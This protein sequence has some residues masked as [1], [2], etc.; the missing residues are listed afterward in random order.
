MAEPAQVEIRR[1]LA[2]LAEQR[3][4]LIERGK[5]LEAEIR[6]AIEQARVEGLSVQEI[7]DLLGFRHRQAVY[8][9]IAE[10]ALPQGQGGRA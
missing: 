8:R 6:E 5:D 10:R 2:E 3:G 7:A 1:R 4:D 9:I